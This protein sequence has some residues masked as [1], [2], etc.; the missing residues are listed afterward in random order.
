MHSQ[1]ESRIAEL[2]EKMLKNRIAADKAQKGA[3]NAL[4]EASESEN[5]C[6]CFL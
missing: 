2:Q 6:N 3:N 5:V 1:L 4:K